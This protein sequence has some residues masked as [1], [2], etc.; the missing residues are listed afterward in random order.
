MAKLTKNLVNRRAFL[1]GTAAAVAAPAAA[2]NVNGAETV[3]IERDISRIV[4]RNISSFRTLDW[5]PYFSTLT[6][7]AVLV[8][9]DSRALHYWGEDGATYKL[10]PSSVPLTEDLT[11]RGRTKVVQKVEGPAGVRHR[12]CESETPSGRNML[13]LVQTTRLEHTRCT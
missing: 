10:Y 9:I 13:D 7:G 3:E 6:G 4:R 8:D 2:Q 1:A 12:R 11:R 5:R